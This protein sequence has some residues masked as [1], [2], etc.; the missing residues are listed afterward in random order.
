[1]VTAKKPAARKTPAKGRAIPGKPGRPSSYSEAMAERILTALETATATTVCQQAW[2]P[3]YKTITRWMDANPEF[4][5]K[6]ARAREAYADKVVDEMTE[7]EDKVINDGLDP[8]A[9]R[10]AIGSK[11]WRAERLNRKKYGNQVGV[12]SAPDLP[13]LPPSQSSTEVN[14][15][16]SAAEAYQAMLRRPTN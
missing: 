5:A 4:A 6:C 16:I 9:A 14:I 11:Q 12:G 1:M 3:D 7:L 2:A 10:V 15:T 8:A 13:P